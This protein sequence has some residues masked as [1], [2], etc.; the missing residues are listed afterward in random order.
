MIDTVMKNKHT[1]IFWIIYSLLV[2]PF[3]LFAQPQHELSDVKATKEAKA[4]YAYINDMFGKNIIRAN[5]LLLG[6]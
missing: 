4:L 6:F 1:Y 5:V 3:T 2:L